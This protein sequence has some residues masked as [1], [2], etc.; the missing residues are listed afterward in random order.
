MQLHAKKPIIMSF[1]ISPFL[2]ILKHH[3][4]LKFRDGEGKLSKG[5]TKAFKKVPQENNF[6]NCHCKFAQI[7]KGYGFG[8]FQR[9]LLQKRKIEIL[10][11]RGFYCQRNFLYFF[12]ENKN[13]KEKKTS[14]PNL[15]FFFK[16]L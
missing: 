5:E 10:L 1:S 13:L 6:L 2:K 11:N 7:E 15:I 8:H 9:F 16:N 14:K 3:S 12:S 4:P